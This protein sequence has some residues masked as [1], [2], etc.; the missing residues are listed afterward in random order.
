MERHPETQEFRN[1]IPLQGAT[2]A[3][4]VQPQGGDPQLSAGPSA[5]LLL[6][7]TFFLHGSSKESVTPRRKSHE[8]DLLGG[9]WCIA[10]NPGIAAGAGSTDWDKGAVLI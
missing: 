6:F 4:A 2:S 8:R 3:E 7:I 9:P 10:V 5:T 1:H